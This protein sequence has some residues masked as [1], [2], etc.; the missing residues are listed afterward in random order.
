M[1][2]PH[3]ASEARALIERF[4]DGEPLGDDFDTAADLIEASL[5]ET[6]APPSTASSEGVMLSDAAIIAAIKVSAWPNTV[7]PTRDFRF[8]PIQD[9][10]RAYWTAVRAALS[11]PHPSGGVEAAPLGWIVGSGDGK[12]WR[13]WSDG[14]SDWTAD[15]EQ[16]TRYAR[17]EDAEAVH[18]E[19]EDAWT[20]VPYAATPSDPS[21][22]VERV[23][24]VFVPALDPYA[25]DEDH[26]LF[27]PLIAVR[28]RA[29]ANFT[30]AFEGAKGEAY[31]RAVLDCLSALKGAFEVLSEQPLWTNGMYL[32]LTDTTGWAS[33]TYPLPDADD[34]RVQEATVKL[35][36]NMVERSGIPRDAPPEEAI[37]IVTRTTT[38]GDAGK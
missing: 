9:T 26:P 1:K 23:A 2:S 6:P 20:I 35:G 18:R 36:R 11:H 30:P 37:A 8:N 34:R 29:A 12:R 13:T 4:R 31:D 10:E 17:R 19:D 7:P 16:A 38:N 14:M 32:M 28:A 25:R 15:R 3:N 33:D 27:A 5:A 21:G 24:G 22:E